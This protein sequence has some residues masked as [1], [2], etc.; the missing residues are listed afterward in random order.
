MPKFF[1]KN[2]GIEAHMWFFR[3]LRHLFFFGII[4]IERN[5]YA[6][7][8]RSKSELKKKKS[9]TGGAAPRPPGFPRHKEELWIS[10]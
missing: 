6:E 9:P 2:R 8:I 5:R 10:K 1:R 4:H 3:K 7:R